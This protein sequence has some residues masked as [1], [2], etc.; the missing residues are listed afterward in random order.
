M[1]IKIITIIIVTVIQIFAEIVEIKS[2]DVFQN[3]LKQPNKLMVF[4]M[5]ADW[6]KPCKML[7]PILLTISDEKKNVQFYRID[8]EKNREIAAAFSATNIPL[9]VYFKNNEFLGKTVGL[10]QKEYYVKIIDYLEK[11]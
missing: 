10:Y 4:D 3:V 6:C 5:Y 7:E 9:V 2:T 8:I 11:N 1:N